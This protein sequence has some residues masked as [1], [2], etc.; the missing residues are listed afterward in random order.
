MHRTGSKHKQYTSP[1]L[2]LPVHTVDSPALAPVQKVETPKTMIYNIY[3][4]LYLYMTVDLWIDSI[5]FTII[6]IGRSDFIN[7]YYQQYYSW[8]IHTAF[9]S[10]CGWIAKRMDFFIV[11][12]ARRNSA[13]K[14]IAAKT[15]SWSGMLDLE[16]RHQSDIKVMT[17]QSG[18]ARVK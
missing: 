14:G 5:I 11:E 10:N 17:P 18:I 1:A 9:T 6:S 13:L 3:H 16:K 4:I 8:G 7:K 2:Q 15:I 12:A